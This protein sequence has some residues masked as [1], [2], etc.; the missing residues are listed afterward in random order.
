MFKTGLLAVVAAANELNLIEA[1]PTDAPC[2]PH[3]I[4]W[5]LIKGEDKF[6]LQSA[7]AEPEIVM[8]GITEIFRVT[9]LWNS[10]GTAM[11]DILATLSVN[12]KQIFSK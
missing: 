4:G 6:V 12:D 2:K 1:E 7:T 11:K 10:D 9:G 8:P 5:M 3:P